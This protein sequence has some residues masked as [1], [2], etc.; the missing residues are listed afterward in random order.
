MKLDEI[1]QTRE[2][3]VAE[4]DAVSQ[5]IWTPRGFGPP[6]ADL[7]PPPPPTKHSFF[8]IYSNCKLLGNVL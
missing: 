4:M 1:V 7:D 5:R 2:G 8:L 6:L 3:A